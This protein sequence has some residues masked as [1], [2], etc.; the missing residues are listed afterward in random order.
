[1]SNSDN[2]LVERPALEARSVVPKSIPFILTVALLDSI[3]MGIAIPVLPGLIEQFSVS[4]ANVG[5]INGLLVALTAVFQFLLSPLI[6]VLSDRFGRRPMLLIATAGFAVDYLI[7]ALAQNLGW[8]VLGR[9]IAGIT[10]ASSATVNAYIAD[11]TLP[12]ERSRAFGLLGAAYSAG[13]LLGP[14]V[15]GLLATISLR[16]PFWMASALSALALVYGACVLAESL[17]LERRMALSWARAQPLGAL[18]L[19]RSKADLRGLTVISFIAFS[20][21][22]VFAVAFVLYTDARYGWNAQ[23]SGILLSL[24]CALEI[25]VQVVLINP[26]AKRIG[27]RATMISALIAGAIGFVCM[28]LASAEVYFILA[29][30]PFG[31]S[32]LAM[33]S[34]QSLMTRQVSESEQGQLQGANVSLIGVSGAVSPIVFGVIY[35]LSVSW[36]KENPAYLGTVFLIAGLMLLIA[37]VLGWFLVKG[38]G[39]D[40]DATS[41]QAG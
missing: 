22:S 39:S 17:P 5:A 19:L 41:R 28:G 25:F 14:L 26:I 15:G 40:A 6:G 23:K 37:G 31:F 20:A 16:A 35:S 24:A 4:N 13:F 9:L 33:P 1:M 21:S 27:D 2:G 12:A 7:L 29:L 32:V 30:M 10:A 11:I 3:V 36:S 18:R 34:L 38:S 8:L